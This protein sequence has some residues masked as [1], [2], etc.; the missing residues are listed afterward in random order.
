M[1]KQILFLDKIPNRKKKESNTRSSL[2]ELRISEFSP[3][4]LCPLFLGRT[5][6]V[7]ESEGQGESSAS[8]RTRNILK[9][10]VAGYS[11]PGMWP[12]WHTSSNQSSP[13]TFHLFILPIYHGLIYSLDQT[14][15]DLWTCPHSHNQRCASLIFLTCLNPVLFTI[16]G[17]S[18]HTGRTGS[19]EKAPSPSSMLVWRQ[20]FTCSNP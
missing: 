6:G 2:S 15:N 1:W 18:S 4:S 19:K 12:Q 16:K 14:W 20:E 10:M 5:S 7:D 11:P 8:W 17:Y 3:L 13:F 9:G